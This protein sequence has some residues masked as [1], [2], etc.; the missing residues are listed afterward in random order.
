MNM[1][2]LH[3][4]FDDVI[5]FG[6]YLFLDPHLRVCTV[7]ESLRKESATQKMEGLLVSK[8]T[9]ACHPSSMPTLSVCRGVRSSQVGLGTSTWLAQAAV[10]P[11][12][13]CLRIVIS[14]RYLVIKEIIQ[15]DLLLDPQILDVHVLDLAGLVRLPMPLTAV[16]SVSMIT[17]CLR[18]K[19]LHKDRMPRPTTPAFATLSS[20]S[21]A[22]PTA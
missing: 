8:D 17:S 5:F 4:S 16:E 21:T 19:S 10:P 18:S 15:R 13:T 1:T 11:K 6:I 3:F 7:N 2:S 12:A 14:S 9:S 22:V 20:H